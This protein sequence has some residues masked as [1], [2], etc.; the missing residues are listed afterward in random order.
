M[1]FYRCLEFLYRQQ[2]AYLIVWSMLL[3]F[4]TTLVVYFIKKVN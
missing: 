3:T 1:V 2:G 4:L